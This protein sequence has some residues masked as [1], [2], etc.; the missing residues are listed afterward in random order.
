MWFGH[1]ST[2][3]RAEEAIAIT[4][5]MTVITGSSRPPVASWSGF[6]PQEPSLVTRV[7]AM[8]RAIGE[9]ARAFKRTAV[10]V[11]MFAT[12]WLISATPASARVIGPCQ[13][14]A[15]I[16]G[17]PYDASFDTPSN[18]IVVP[19]KRAGLEIPYSGSVSMTN[20]NYLGAVGVVIGPLTVNIGD[21]GLDPNDDDVTSTDPGATYVLG[22]ELDNIVGIYQL[23]AF[24]DADGGS[25]D[26]DAYVKLEGPVLPT[27]AGGG[28]TAAAVITGLGVVA[29]G[30]VKGKP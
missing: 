28:S 3:R 30:R 19:E 16:D 5:S 22:S 18:P 15:T 2:K 8:V 29:A 14:T 23:T 27:P 1:A 6:H 24:H 7:K 20:T 9:A 21:W 26:A 4:L 17:V 12:I 25:C 13:G 11:A 10:I